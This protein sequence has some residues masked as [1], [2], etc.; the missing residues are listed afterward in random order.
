MIVIMQKGRTVI[1]A[2]NADDVTRMLA[3]G[4]R[5]LTPAEIAAAGMTGHEHLVGPHN[6]TV[7]EDGTITFTP[8]PPP[9]LE[10]VKAAKLAE[11]NSGCQVAL[12]ALT[13]TYPERELHSFANQEREARE[14]QAAPDTAQTPLLSALA[15]ARGIG[16]A[17]LVD[18]VLAKAAAFAVASGHII[19]QRQYMEDM[20]DVCETVEAVQA[21]AVNYNWEV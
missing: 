15:A 8:P 4:W 10:E 2:D 21:I 16:L 1:N 6:T 14:Y 11:I 19:G 18:K 17:E 12:E 7:G 3:D 9:A 13:P 20:L 5:E